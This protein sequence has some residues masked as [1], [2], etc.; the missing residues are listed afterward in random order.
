MNYLFIYFTFQLNH[1]KYY[2]KNK[3]LG[4]SLVVQW[5]RLSVPN[6]RSPGLLSGRRTRSHMLQRK[7]KTPC[8]AAKTW[9]SQ[10]SK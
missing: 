7:S 4:T 5:L 2:Y 9:C 8:A 6:A 3:T 10:T 1:I